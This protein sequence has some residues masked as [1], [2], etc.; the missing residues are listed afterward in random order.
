[1][2]APTFS[3]QA[4]SQGL[5]VQPPTGVTGSGQW[6]NVTIDS[7]QESE[8]ST[9]I[10]Y[11]TNAAGQ[12]ISRDQTQVGGNVSLAD[13]TLAQ[14]GVIVTDNG[15]LLQEGQASVYLRP[16]QFLRVAVVAGDGSVIEDLP[17]SNTISD[18]GQKDKAVLTTEDFTFIGQLVDNLSPKDWLANAQLQQN[19]PIYFFQ[20]NSTIQVAVSGSCTLTNTLKWVP[21]T[22]D[23]LTGQKTVGGAIAADTDAFRDSLKKNAL[24]FSITGTGQQFNETQELKITTE[25]YYA[26]F[27]ETSA[28]NTFFIGTAANPNNQSHFRLFGNGVFGVEDLPG[29]NSGDFDFND[30]VVRLTPI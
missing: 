2:T 22:F 19:E 13:A 27:L 24:D 18:G 14:I 28:G 7:W 11:A 1:M 6:M 23:P 4:P 21:V 15:S 20:A 3:L 17:V 10:L 12:L 30:M 26:P 8:N 29:A 16:D 25:G 9:F 5:T